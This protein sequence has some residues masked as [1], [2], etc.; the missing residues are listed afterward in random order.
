MVFKLISRLSAASSKLGKSCDD[1]LITSSRRLGDR[2]LHKQ[3]LD[4]GRRNGGV[5]R[6][7]IGACGVDFIPLKIATRL[8]MCKL[9]TRLEGQANTKKRLTQKLK[10]IL[11]QR[12]NII[13]LDHERDKADVHDVE[14]A[15]KLRRRLAEHIP[16]VQLD[17]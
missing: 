17:I 10:D 12:E 9:V 15:D 13:V 8:F 11:N 1:I 2:E 5:G 4:G 3:A 7:D 14:L 6:L 16:I